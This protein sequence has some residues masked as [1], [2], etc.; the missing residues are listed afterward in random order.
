VLLGYLEA[1]VPLSGS[2]GGRVRSF[3]ERRQLAVAELND[4]PTGPIWMAHGAELDRDQ[5]IT[6]ALDQLVSSVDP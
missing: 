5:L 1:H 4:H 6:Y 2:G 3:V